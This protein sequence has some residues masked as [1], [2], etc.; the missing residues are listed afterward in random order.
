MNTEPVWL[1]VA[2][3]GGAGQSYQPNIPITPEAIIAQG[4]ECAQA[5]AAIVH[6]HVYNEQGV[7]VEDA[8]LYS[9]VIEGIKAKC[10]VIVYPTLGL[11]GSIEQ[12]FEPIRIL[13]ERGL[14]EWGVVDPGSVNISHRSMVEN[15]VDGIHYPNPDA[16]IRAGLD[17]AQE[18]NWRPAYAIYEPGFARLGAAMAATYA[19]LKNPIYR[20]M[21]SDN[22]LFGMQPSPMAVCFYAEHL[23]LTA[24]GAPWML[25]GLDADIEAIAPLALD[26]GAHLRVGLE[27]APFGTDKTNMQLL[28]FALTTIDSSGRS[29]ATAAQIRA[30]A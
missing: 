24:P 10:D 1:E 9:R 11:S 26:L 7:S 20:I 25:S 15:G 6:L 3:N 4:I 30:T 8:D 21:L 5:G 22:L 19:N 13:A 12:R 17:L 23:A 18:N 29:L 2:L 14:L 16:H 28:E 27:D